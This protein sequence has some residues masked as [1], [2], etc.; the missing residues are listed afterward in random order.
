MQRVN[1]TK[2]SKLYLIDPSTGKQYHLLVAALNVSAMRKGGLYVVKIGGYLH[3]SNVPRLMQVLGG[4]AET[5]PAG[6]NGQQSVPYTVDVTGLH[7]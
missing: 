3:E 4:C 6:S 2:L 7:V 5:K 1:E